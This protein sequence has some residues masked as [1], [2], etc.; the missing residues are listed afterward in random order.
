MARPSSRKTSTCQPVRREVETA[1]PEERLREFHAAIHAMPDGFAITP[2]LARQWDRRAQTARYAR[3]ARSTGR[4]PSRSAFAAIISDGTPIRLTGQDAERGTFSQRHLVL[5][6][7]TTDAT[8]HA[9]AALPGAQGQFRGL[10]QPALRGGGASASSTATACMRR[11]ALV[12]WEA[13]FGD[14]A[15]GA[16]IIID[17]F[18]A[19]ARSKWRQHAVAGAA[20]AARLRGPGTG[21]LQRPPRALPAAFGAGQ[22]PGRQLHDRGPVLPPAAP[23]G[24]APG[25]SIRAR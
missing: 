9:V 18:I 25:R 23:P 22:H 13:Q 5:H 1:V 15:N 11:V 6:D 24:A 17:Q 20:A 2:K 8:L 4:T 21:A 12:L 7:P 19:A 16:Q 3:T 14:F 10:Q